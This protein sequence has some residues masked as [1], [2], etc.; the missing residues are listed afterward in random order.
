MPRALFPFLLL[1]L[2]LVA[3]NRLA[4]FSPKIGD[5]IIL[6]QRESQAYSVPSGGSGGGDRAM[7]G[8]LS[9]ARLRNAL[10]AG[11]EESNSVSVPRKV[12]RSG[13][14]QIVVDDPQQVVA[15]VTSL[16][17]SLGGYVENASVSGSKPKAQSAQMTLRLPEGKLDD[18]R[19]A[20][21]KLAHSV[22]R[23]SVE[24][25]DVTGEYVD[26][27]ARLRSLKAQE[28]QYLALMKRATAVKDMTEIQEK[29]G[30][31][32][33]EIEAQEA[34]FKFLSN[35]IAMA[36][37]S[38]AIEP[39][40]E[41]K[42]AGIYWH[43]WATIRRSARNLGEGL[44]DFADSLIEFVFYLPIIAL[45]LVVLVLGTKIVFRVVKWLWKRFMPDSQLG[46]WRK[47]P[48][49]TA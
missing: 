35:Q 49:G 14:M 31:L 45:W 22:E 42:V 16:A 23:D 32:R 5:N 30:E 37:L 21:R 28:Q 44:I 8:A 18:A 41:A 6:D 13:G 1:A 26:M 48:E 12:I 47:K 29:L 17:Q 33:Q 19:E 4:R 7:V 34:Q 9:P 24:A 3:C 15:R 27:D 2:S 38:V 39:V 20:I 10:L 46:F 25:K 40:A 43:P 11:Y 36:S